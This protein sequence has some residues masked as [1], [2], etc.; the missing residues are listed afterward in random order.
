MYSAIYDIL[1]TLAGPCQK[2]KVILYST[3]IRCSVGYKEPLDQLCMTIM[4]AVD[5]IKSIINYVHEVYTRQIN[6]LTLLLRVLQ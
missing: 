2:Y 4:H 5:W 6:M 1:Y 3:F